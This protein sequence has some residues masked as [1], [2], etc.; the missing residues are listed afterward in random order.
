MRFWL[1]KT[2]GDHEVIGIA[3]LS[4]PYPSIKDGVF[5]VIAEDIGHSEWWLDEITR[6]EF[7]TYQAFGFKEYKI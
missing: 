2:N 5:R 3:K 4:W 1:I 6:T 7:E